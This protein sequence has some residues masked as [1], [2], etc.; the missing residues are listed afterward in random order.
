LEVAVI[1]TSLEESISAC[2]RRDKESVKV[3][4]IILSKVSKLRF[5]VI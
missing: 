5:K 2:P 4:I 3:L 1:I